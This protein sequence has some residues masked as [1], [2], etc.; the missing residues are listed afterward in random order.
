MVGNV[1]FGNDTDLQA[2]I[3]EPLQQRSDLQEL[4][5]QEQMEETLFLGL[6]MVEG[7]SFQKFAEVFG[8]SMD[9]VYGSVIEKN[10]KDGLLV[11]EEADCDRRLSLTSKGMD[12]SN[13]VMAQFLLD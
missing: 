1:R 12:V 11:V 2:Y 10:R 8:Q 6:R 5:L 3:R 7:V 4:T 9:E 13:Y